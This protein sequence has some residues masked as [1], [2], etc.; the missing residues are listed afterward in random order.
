VIGILNTTADVLSQSW[1]KPVKV[2]PFLEVLGSH[3]PLAFAYAAALLAW[4]RSGRAVAFAAPVAAA[5]RMA[6]T[7]YLM[8]S[9]VFALLFYGYGFQL[10]GRLDP[11]TATAIG[12]AFYA[13]QLWFSAWWL[14][15]Y[16][17]GPFEWLWRS[18]TYG[19]RQ[20]MRQPP[21]VST[22]TRPRAGVE[23]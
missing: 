8:Q 23:T 22:F 10:F 9:A 19:R 11:R 12:V 16:R 17:F 14:K 5:G 15:Q 3:V 21:A 6:L 7:N 13:G 20:P 4:R 1:G 2:A 18:L